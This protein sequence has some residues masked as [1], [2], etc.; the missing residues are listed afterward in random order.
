MTNKNTVHKSNKTYSRR[1]FIKSA[2]AS[3]AMLSF[4]ISTALGFPSKGNIKQ[5]KVVWVLLRGALDALH[6]VIPASDPQYQA[7]RPNL[8]TQFKSPLLPLEKNFFLNPAL[9]NMHKWYLQQSLLPIVSVS[10][11]YSNR[12]HFDGQDFLE[13]G[14]INIDHDTGW[15]A[16]ALDTKKK[17]AVAISRSTPI[18]LRSS[19]NVN[20]WYPSQL[21]KADE[22]IYTTLMNMYQH[23]HKLADSLKSGLNIQSMTNTNKMKN[24]KGKFSHLTEN[25]AKLLTGENALD[26]AMLE[27][28]GWDTH[29]NQHNRL[30]RKLTELDQGLEKLKVGLGNEWENTVIIIGTEFGRTVKEN[31]TGGTDH[32]TASTLFLAGGAINGG[33]VKGDWPGLKAEQL[34]QNRDLMPTSNTFSWISTLLSQHWQLSQKDLRS[35]FPN[36]KLYKEKLLLS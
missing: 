18:S 30:N 4:P 14:S 33:M 21:E 8:S 7:L 9:K 36:I 32:G 24:K 12:S 6:T 27:L 16:R 13:S 28:G 10:T 25:C 1:K 22:N 34:Y 19:D 2:T 31:G 3:I 5:P 11:G 17:Q 26:C 23:D 20:T 35:V 15:L 29:N